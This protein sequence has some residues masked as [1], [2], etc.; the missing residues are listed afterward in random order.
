MPRISVTDVGGQERDIDATAGLSLMENLQNSDV[1]GIWAICGGLM[2]CATCHIYLDDESFE[3]VGA[4]GPTETNLLEGSGVRRATSRLSCQ[5]EVEAAHEGLR[6]TV[7][8]E[9]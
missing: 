9:K 7:A 4:P 5:I 8:P 6:L 1:D 2:A 3:R